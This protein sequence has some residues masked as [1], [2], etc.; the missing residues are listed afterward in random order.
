LGSFHGPYLVK[1]PRAASKLPFSNSRSTLHA[2]KSRYTES[3]TDAAAAASAWSLAACDLDF[4]L[5]AERR[6]RLL[7]PPSP[8]VATDGASTLA[9]TFFTPFDSL[10][11]EGS[12]FADDAGTAFFLDFFLGG[13]VTTSASI[14]TSPSAPGSSSP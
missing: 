14:S 1:S 9:S 11:L 10:L 3:G 6:C 7:P 4:D 12:V 8:L 13:G 2:V 5:D